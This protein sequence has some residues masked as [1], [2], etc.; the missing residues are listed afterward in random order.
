MGSPTRMCVA[1]DL[2]SRILEPL[3]AHQRKAQKEGRGVDL[4]LQAGDGQTT[5]LHQVRLFLS[6][7]NFSL[8]QVMVIPRSPMLRNLALSLEG[9][10]SLTLIIPDTLSTTL[11]LLV[12]LLYGSTI[13]ITTQAFAELCSL[14]TS[15]DLHDWLYSEV[16]EEDSGEKSTGS[17]EVKF[18]ETNKEEDEKSVT[19]ISLDSDSAE[20]RCQICGK[21]YLNEV[22]LQRHYNSAHFNEDDS[23]T[24]IIQQTRRKQKLEQGAKK[25]N[26]QSE[27]ADLSSPRLSPTKRKH[28]SNPPP[29]AKVLR[30]ETD[31]NIDI[32]QVKSPRIQGSTFL[33]WKLQEVEEGRDVFRW[34]NTCFNRG[35]CQNKKMT[36]KQKEFCC[37]WNNFLWIEV[38]LHITNKSPLY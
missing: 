29:L 27:C 7:G 32:S 20:P 34:Q 8:P 31:E 12:S 35:L 14:C 38:H 13:P 17:C 30:S 1:S 6:V 25:A 36:Q 22:R 2:K 9:S 26:N 21:W 10:P 4:H 23:S 24:L 18:K 3:L 37:L 11:Q 19:V 16:R 15:L 33:P 5:S 28:S